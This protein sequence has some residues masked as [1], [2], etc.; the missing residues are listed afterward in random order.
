MPVGWSSF[1]RSFALKLR[2]EEEEEKEKRFFSLPHLLF[3]FGSHL[4]SASELDVTDTELA[5][6]ASPASAG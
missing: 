2:K 4:L 3:F 5:A 6:I 1:C